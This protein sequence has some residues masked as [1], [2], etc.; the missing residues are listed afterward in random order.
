VLPK[1]E[2]N[3]V[4]SWAVRDWTLGAYLAYGSG[5][6]ILAP[7]SNNALASSLFQSTFANRVSGQ[8]LFNQDL[9]CHCF[10]PNTTF[11]LNPKAWTDPPAGQFGA[12]AA[13]Y[14]DYRQ[15]RRP[16]ENFN[17][18]RTFRIRE[19]ANL[20]IRAEFTNV[21]NRTEVS[22]PT[23]TNAGAAQTRNAAGQTTAGFGWIN[24]TGVAAPP[25]AGTLIA[26]I[27]F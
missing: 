8:P 10:D 1:L 16:A 24:T 23:S 3:K 4:L 11:V 6:P 7:A 20:N 26:R 15:Q 13:Y 21:F 9:N 17:F 27:Q 18:G 14:S 19:R 2:I 5:L 22:N 12:S 25:R